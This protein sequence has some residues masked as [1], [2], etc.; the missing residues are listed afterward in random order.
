MSCLDYFTRLLSRRD[1]SAYELQQKGK[2]K[3]FE[4]EEVEGAID[5][6]Q[7]LGYQS[8]RRLVERLIAASVGKHGKPVV[9]R[10]CW[11]KGINNELFETIWAEQEATVEKADN[12]SELK[13]KI[14]RKYK[15]D[16]WTN[17]EPNTK[18][19]V[20]N[21]LQYRGFNPFETWEQWQREDS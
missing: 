7:Y 5:R 3:G 8:D 10:Q 1:Y 15:I 19:K 9:K 11:Q 2:E 13:A 6:L 20:F 21:Y 4:L 12:L 18:R 17:L 14:S 16:D